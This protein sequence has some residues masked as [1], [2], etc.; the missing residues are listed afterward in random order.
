MGSKVLFRAA[1][2]IFH[3]EQLIG[4]FHIGNI[5]SYLVDNMIKLHA[6]SSRVV[7]IIPS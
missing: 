3:I 2:I 4:H 1:L 6:L 7:F 5:S